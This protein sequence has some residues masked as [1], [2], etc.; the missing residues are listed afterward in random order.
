[1]DMAYV[2]TYWCSNDYPLLRV[3]DGFHLL[4]EV[5][6]TRILTTAAKTLDNDL[7]QSRKSW[8]Q[9]MPHTKKRQTVWRR[10]RMQTQVKQA[11]PHLFTVSTFQRFCVTTHI[12]NL[13]R[14]HNREQNETVITTFTV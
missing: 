10:T 12:N 11:T 14:G 9:R 4:Y 3:R 13:G 7:D 8:P 1:M 5:Q 2:Y 6:S